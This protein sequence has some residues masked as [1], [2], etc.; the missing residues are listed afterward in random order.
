LWRIIR[1]TLVLLPL[2]LVIG[3]YIRLDR[4]ADQALRDALAETDRLDPGWR[5]DE[6]EA[7][8]Q[9]VLPEENSAPQILK[10]KALVLPDWWKDV[11]DLQV[12]SFAPERQMS[13]KQLEALRNAMERVR[14]A[15]AEAVRLADMPR[16]RFP[17]VVRQNGPWDNPYVQSHE[18]GSI[19]YL[20]GHEIDLRVQEGDADG[21]LISCRAMLNAG[22]AIG[23]EP[24]LWS[25]QLRIV[26]QH[27]AVLKMERTL[28]QGEPSEATLEA[29]Q[30]LLADEDRHPAM[31]TG[32]RGERA[33][34]DLI[35]Q[36]L[37]DGSNL[38]GSFL[39]VQRGSAAVATPPR[40]D[41]LSMIASGSL[42]GQRAALLRVHSD[43]VQAAKLPPDQMNKRLQQVM[44]GL[45]RFR[46]PAAVWLF[47][48]PPQVQRNEQYALLRSAVV[49]LAV[50]RY[51]RQQDRWPDTLDALVPSFL[52]DVPLDPQDGQRLRYRQLLDGVVIYSVGP[53]LTD[54][55]GNLDRQGRAGGGTD[56]GVRLWDVNRRRQP[57]GPE[58][59]N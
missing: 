1:I 14:E 2:G 13:G 25:Q 21:A 10:A 46:S 3:E 50:E 9:I 36:A 35:M 23:D 18:A 12:D 20:L 7:K 42:K 45:Q 54:N 11:H 26:E 41:E 59:P 38:T 4:A 31:L 48:Y 19:G 49:A 6:L 58:T 34:A 17:T 33:T 30:R 37:Q 39:Q 44:S 56:I 29:L 15:V 55:G 47:V 57:P 8:R 22:R 53:D 32:L 16:G 28:A 43:L 5:L 52:P 27:A 51:R 24:R 40:H